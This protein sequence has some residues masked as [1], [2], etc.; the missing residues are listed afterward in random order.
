MQSVSRNADGAALCMVRIEENTQHF[1]DGQIYDQSSSFPSSF[2][3]PPHFHH[4]RPCNFQLPSTLFPTDT[5]KSLFSQFVTM[6]KLILTIATAVGLITAQERSLPPEWEWPPD[7]SRYH[8]SHCAE[9][10]IVNGVFWLSGLA[11]ENQTLEY[12]RC[13]STPAEVTIADF[14][15][16]CAGGDGEGSA[17]MS[18][19]LQVDWLRRQCGWEHI[20]GGFPYDRGIF[21][22]LQP[23]FSTIRKQSHQH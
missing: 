21:V 8:L 22:S 15:C 20:F 10:A 9:G 16:F 3:S 23:F 6:K 13:L 12:N 1:P 7:L 14:K 18:E 19:A 17:I 4:S 11:D 2:L 5:G